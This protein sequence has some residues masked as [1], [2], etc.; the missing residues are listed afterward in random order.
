MEKPSLSWPLN[1]ANESVNDFSRHCKINT[2]KSLH[3]TPLYGPIKSTRQLQLWALCPPPRVPR[4]V[5]VEV[6]EEAGKEEEHW[7]RGDQSSPFA[8]G[9]LVCEMDVWSPVPAP[10]ISP[11]FRASH[12]GECWNGKWSLGSIPV[13]FLR[14]ER[15]QAHHLIQHPSAHTYSNICVFTVAAHSARTLT[16][17]TLFNP[18]LMPVN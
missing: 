13:W 12:R 15:P 18:H 8:L 11:H 2:H 10:S 6:R 17:C 4:L 16:L 7:S 5:Q 1:P 14:A 3:S 9:F